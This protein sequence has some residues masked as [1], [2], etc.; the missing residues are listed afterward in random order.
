MVRSLLLQLARDLGERERR[1]GNALFVPPKAH[2]IVQ[3]Y[4]QR[5]THKVR[6]Q[7]PL[8]I[9]TPQ[10]EPEV[11]QF[12]PRRFD[13]DSVEVFEGEVGGGGAVCGGGFYDAEDGFVEVGL[14]GGEVA[15]DG[16][17]SCV[18]ERRVSRGG[19]ESGRHGGDS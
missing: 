18:R 4:P 6:I 13:A 1:K 10:V 17:S 3:V 7:H 12:G 19:R 11:P 14:G 2:R 15:G 8:Q 9:P 16:E 5:V